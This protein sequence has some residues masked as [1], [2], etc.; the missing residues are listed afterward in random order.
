MHPWHDYPIDEATIADHFPA[1]IEVPMGS[2][3]KYKLEKSIDDKLRTVCIGDPAFAGHVDFRELPKHVVR[4]M[5]RFFQDTRR[6]RAR[7]SR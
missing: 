7:R 1:I 2:K 4:E 3:N 5:L 6:S